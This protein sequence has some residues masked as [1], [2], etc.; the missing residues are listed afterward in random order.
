V[1]TTT[2]PDGLVEKFLTDGWYDFV[3]RLDL[4][5]SDKIYLTVLDPVVRVCVYVQRRHVV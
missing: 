4:K 3:R 1:R 2:K 5:P